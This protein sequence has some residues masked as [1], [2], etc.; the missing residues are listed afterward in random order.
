MAIFRVGQ[1]TPSPGQ[2]LTASVVS[3]LN[4]EAPSLLKVRL[5][6]YWR[7]FESSPEVAPVTWALPRPVS[8]GL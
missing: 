4:W 1:V 3:L 5:T 2:L 7:P 6:A 8:C